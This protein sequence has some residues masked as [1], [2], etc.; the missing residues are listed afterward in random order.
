MRPFSYLL[1]WDLTEGFEA[2][3]LVDSVSFSALRAAGE[4]EP[5][6]RGASGC[7]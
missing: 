5:L 7:V 4:V 6:A 2:V 1:A 3:V